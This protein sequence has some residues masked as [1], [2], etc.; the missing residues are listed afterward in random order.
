MKV[1]IVTDGPYGER[2]YEY[3]SM[4]FD[5][6][7]LEVEKPV[8]MFADEIEIPEDVS[9]KIKGSDILITY[10]LHPDLTFDIVEMLHDKVGWVI[11]A[12]WRGEGFKNQ[13]ENFGNVTCPEN[14]CDL[15]ENGN[16]VFD[17]FVSKFGR[18]IVRIN[19]QG[20][21]I[22]DIEVLRSSP[23]GATYFVAEDMVGK[24]MEDLP[25]KAGL[26]IQHY[27]CRAPKMRLFADE[28][29]KDMASNFHKEAFEN[30][31]KKNSIDKD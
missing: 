31:L 1:V 7:F 13:L 18:P 16:P 26:R 12:A 4:E 24:D 23:C 3:I 6:E 14:M 22:V 9:N 28:C 10:T 2:A 27:P 5:T 21:K 20:D 30:A 11:V 15:E 25:I 29:K 17:E 19:C 8:S